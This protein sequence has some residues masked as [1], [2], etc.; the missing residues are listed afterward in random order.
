M[1]GDQ[2][3]RQWKLLAMLEK[4]RTGAT[5]GE[6]SAELKVSVR[7]VYRDLEVL[8]DVGV[9]MVA[10]RD[11]AE[12]SWRLA[13]DCPWSKGVPLTL[14]EVVALHVAGDFLDARGSDPW[15]EG[16]RAALEKVRAAVPGKLLERLR[17]HLEVVSASERGR[18]G[19]ATRPGVVAT[20]G[21]ALC[22]RRRLMMIY[23]TPGK[24]KP[25]PRLVE[26]LRLHL[27]D[28]G[29][30]LIADDAK[31]GEVRTFLVDRI[32]KVEILEERFEPKGG[33]DLDA[34][35]ADAFAIYRGGHRIHLVAMLDEGI[36]HLARERR[37][38][39][40]Q[41]LRQHEGGVELHLDVV[42]TPELRAWLRGF[43]PALTVVKPA[44]LVK[45]FA[46]EARELLRRY[47]PPPRERRVRGRRE[48]A[49]RS[50][51]RKSKEVRE[52]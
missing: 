47:A 18:S 16:L 37:W 8:Q 13:G 46:E 50:R 33:F 6:L 52:D 1:R 10:E 5:V 43:G 40:S 36:A 24:K 51:T 30:Y 12:V 21:R 48:M 9:P 28:G 15:S 25:G 14:D 17:E 27:H 26:P 22:E 49:A 45:A 2:L 29:L 32:Q 7:T 35:F 11:G 42:D 3:T 20:V 41:E 34:Y 23:A 38:H 31:R 19:S 39:P 44:A 4:R